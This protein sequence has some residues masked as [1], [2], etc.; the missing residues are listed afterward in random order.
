MK[1]STTFFLLYPARPGFEEGRASGPGGWG[2]HPEAFFSCPGPQKRL[3]RGRAA[4]VPFPHW[5]ERRAG[6]QNAKKTCLQRREFGVQFL[7]VAAGPWSR[8]QPPG[9]RRTGACLRAKGSERAPHGAPAF[10]SGL[11]WAIAQF[12][13]AHDWQS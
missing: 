7:S 6:G 4:S 12:G 1:Y 9:F 5:P 11:C 3:N 2:W 10:A 8:P 13:R